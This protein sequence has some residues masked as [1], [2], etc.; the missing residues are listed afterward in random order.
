M[1][2]VDRFGDDRDGGIARFMDGQ[3]GRIPNTMFQ[4]LMSLV[5]SGSAADNARRSLNSRD[6]ALRLGGSR[7]RRE[8]EAVRMGPR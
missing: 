8:V 3:F 2:G 7:P 5:T 1:L 6:I 4:D